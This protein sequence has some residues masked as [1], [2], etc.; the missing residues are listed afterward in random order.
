VRTNLPRAL[1]DESPWHGQIH[2]FQRH[3][4]LCRCTAPPGLT[5]TPE[6]NRQA[7]LRQQ[8]IDEEVF[9]LLH[10]ERLAWTRERWE[11][12]RSELEERQCQRAYAGGL[13]STADLAARVLSY[14]R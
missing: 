11:R 12:A 8:D 9:P 7:R 10:R 6:A 5:L 4:E 1:S 2:V 13:T 14:G 3:P